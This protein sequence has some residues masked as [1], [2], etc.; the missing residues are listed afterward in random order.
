MKAAIR[1]GIGAGIVGLALVTP[2]FAAD[3]TGT[4]FDVLRNPYSSRWVIGAG[5]GAPL[6]LNPLSAPPPAGGLFYDQTSQ[7][8]YTFVSGAWSAA[9]QIRATASASNPSGACTTG[10]FV[11][12]TTT[13]HL[14][15][16]VGGSTWSDVG[17][18][19]GAA[20]SF[21]IADNVTPNSIGGY[22]IKTRDGKL[23]IGAPNG[24]ANQNQIVM[25]Q[26]EDIDSEFDPGPWDGSSSD[27][28][29]LRVC[30][31]DV[32]ADPLR[33]IEMSYG[34]GSMGVPQQGYFE[35][36]AGNIV[37]CPA[38]GCTSQLDTSGIGIPVNTSIHWMA[39]GVGNVADVGIARSGTETIC[40]NTGGVNCAALG[41][42]AVDAFTASSGT[43]SGAGGVSV[44]GS[45]IALSSNL[46]LVG[47]STTT[48]GFFYP[49]LGGQ[50]PDTVGIGVGSVSNS[51]HIAES[52]DLFNG[53]DFNN[54]LAGT[55]ANTHPA[56]VISPNALST[57]G[58]N[59][60]DFLGS[61]G[62]NLKA[63]TDNTAT[64]FFHTPTIAAGEA[65]I[66]TGTYSVKVLNSANEVQV[67]SGTYEW[68][69]M[70]GNTGG[71]VCGIKSVG[72][73]INDISSG[74]LSTDL[75]CT[76]ASNVASF[77]MTADTSLTATSFFMVAQANV[78][79]G[80]A[81]VIAN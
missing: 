33:C 21:V 42:L 25:M 14:W 15:V 70:N 75:T 16:C 68:Y 10:D 65:Y 61:H 44:T 76:V 64:V 24:A 46:G 41:D 1:S 37:V 40:V 78:R 36:G 74:T 23:L 59:Q 53:D 81:A 7:R 22:T 51:L 18:A 69:A 31:P 12:Q 8:F 79:I 28:T 9:S 29:A 38:R 80:P 52:A 56:I 3:D 71:S 58:Y 4:N 11:V 43:F 55:G 49:N 6:S 63:L 39:L 30:G 60:L 45:N 62:G 20:A 2:L 77:K 17:P 54:G 27:H 32:Q 47:T 19:S 26:V 66:G 48:Q 34:G 67:A 5:F 73:G 13:Q 35:T 57:P 72:N 50:T